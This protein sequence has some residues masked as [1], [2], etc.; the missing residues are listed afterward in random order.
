MNL[1]IFF[2]IDQISSF[3]ALNIPVDRKN[4]IMIIP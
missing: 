4:Y 3:I 1:I 2:H